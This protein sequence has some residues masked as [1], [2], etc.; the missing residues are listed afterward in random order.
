MKISL[1][2]DEI[3]GGSGNDQERLVEA[4][5][6]AARQ[7]DFEAR[8]ALYQHYVPLLTSLAKK[9]AGEDVTQV[10]ALIERG[11]DGLLNAAK[12]Y[13]PGKTTEK[14]KLFALDYIEKAM[15]GGDKGF[16]SRIFGK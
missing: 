9:R 16:L 10:N 11:K 5:V 12:R 15:D 2:L 14:F 4:W 3:G 13:K 1:K 6:A 8:Q 7:G